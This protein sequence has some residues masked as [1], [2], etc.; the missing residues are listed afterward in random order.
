MRMSDQLHGPVVVAM[1][2]MRMMQPSTHKVIDVVAVRDRLVSTA[3][4]MLMA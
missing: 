3:R 4:T 2:A 1:I